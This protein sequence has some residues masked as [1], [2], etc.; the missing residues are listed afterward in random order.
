MNL[1]ETIE[2]RDHP[3]K[4]R[5]ANSGRQQVANSP[6]PAW[7]G[8]HLSPPRRA[9]GAGRRFCPWE[10]SAAASPRPPAAG[11]GALRAHLRGPPGAGGWKETEARSAPFPSPRR[12]AGGPGQEEVP[13]KKL[14]RAE[15][16]GPSPAAPNLEW[17]PLRPQEEYLQPS[18][19]G[20]ERLG[21]TRQP[22]ATAIQEV[23]EAAARNGAPVLCADPRRRPQG[24][25]AAALGRARASQH[26]AQQQSQSR[27]GRAEPRRAHR[28]PAVPRSD[29]GSAPARAR[30]PAP[31]SSREWTSALGAVRARPPLTLPGKPLSFSPGSKVLSCPGEARGKPKRTASCGRVAV[32][33]ASARHGLS[34]PAKETFSPPPR[35]GAPSPRAAE[36]RGGAAKARASPL[37]CR[38]LR[39]RGHVTIT[40]LPPR[41]GAPRKQS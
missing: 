28:G 10:L 26:R 15:H 7:Q 21:Q 8:S 23:P 9:P 33:A 35:S 17:F 16:P 4:V 29:P 40:R 24:P 20:R 18:D 19:P 11:W 31:T 38:A 36:P 14:L 2:P 25:A 32:G 1:L 3:L 41:V 6:A 37:A 34:S 30:G 39:P 22:L 12:A 13:W 5:T 27:R